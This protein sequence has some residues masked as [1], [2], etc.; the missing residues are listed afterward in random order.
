LFQKRVSDGTDASLDDGIGF[1]F[2]EVEVKKFAP[3]KSDVLGDLE[4]QQHEL[5]LTHQEKGFK[6]SRI[7]I[8]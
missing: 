8:T 1:P 5:K 7:Q 2:H 6:R 4:W 3:Q